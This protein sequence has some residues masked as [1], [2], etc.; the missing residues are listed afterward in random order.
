MLATILKRIRMLFYKC[1]CRVRKNH[2][3]KNT[4]I[5]YGGM[6]NECTIGDYVHIGPNCILN[7]TVI[8]NYSSIA[9][10]V[11]IGG[12]EHPYEEL[13]TSTFLTDN[14]RRVITEIGHDVWIA[15]GTIIKTGVRIGNGAVVGANSFVNKDVPPYAIVFGIPA[16]VFKYR[17]D[18]RIIAELEKS[19]YW[20]QEPGN[21]R[22]TLLKIKRN[23]S[24]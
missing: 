8:G 9:P 20:E 16:K 22:R 5:Y 2:V 3:G 24:V 10:H 14:S 1:F 19:R 15:A 4:Y 21:A 17:F 6:M 23:C 12:M 7:R 13:S 11:Q 18:E